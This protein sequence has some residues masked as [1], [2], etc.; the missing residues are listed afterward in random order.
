MT[1]EKR[2]VDDTR[3]EKKEISDFQRMTMSVEVLR[4]RP[5]MI[6]NSL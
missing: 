2:I 1:P 6:P 3:P 4:A 5:D